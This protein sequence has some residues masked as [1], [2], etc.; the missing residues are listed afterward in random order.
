MG[1]CVPQHLVGRY[2]CVWGRK[3]CGDVRAAVDAVDDDG[4]L[5]AAGVVR[6]ECLADV[7]PALE[8]LLVG[9]V[10]IVQLLDFDMHATTL[11]DEPVGLVLH[12][13]D[14][15]STHAARNLHVR[16]G[17]PCRERP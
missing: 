17:W 12:R 3:G 14:F 1:R 15:V 13:R 11:E 5:D 4:A 7:A 10:L 8:L 6:G 16:W 9:L 2:R